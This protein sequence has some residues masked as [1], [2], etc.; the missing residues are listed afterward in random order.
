[1]SEPR[2]KIPKIPL[3]I[4]SRDTF[5]MNYYST[6]MEYLEGSLKRLQEYTSLFEKTGNIG[7]ELAAYLADNLQMARNY[8]LMFQEN[9]DWYL[10]KK[11]CY[12]NKSQVQEKDRVDPL[13][14]QLMAELETYRKK[15]EDLRSVNMK[16]KNM[17]LKELN[18]PRTKVPPILRRPPKLSSTRE[19]VSFL[20]N[21]YPSALINLKK[22][23]KMPNSHSFNFGGF[24]ETSHKSTSH[25][26]LCTN[27][28]SF[29]EASRNNCREEIGKE[30]NDLDAE[31][32][33]L[34]EMIK[35]E[36]KK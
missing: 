21:C 15:V 35:K 11:Q 33:E 34:S 16:L 32:F 3:K 18:P 2:K 36:V 19:N 28:S 14:K 31:I 27:T 9:Q 10:K 29:F 5:S 20:A 12:T 22:Q 30:I 7:K 13:A 8:F 24:T 23:K 26:R 25:L 17:S 6:A 1:M 4:N